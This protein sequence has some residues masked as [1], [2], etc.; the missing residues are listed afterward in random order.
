MNLAISCAQTFRVSDYAGGCNGARV[1]FANGGTQ[2][3]TK[4][5]LALNILAPVY[6]KYNALHADSLTWADLI[7]LAGS[8][9]LQQA[10]ATTCGGAVEVP[11]CPG[12]TDASGPGDGESVLGFAR[13]VTLSKTLTVAQLEFA[14]IL[15]G[16]SKR[17]TVALLGLGSYGSLG[18]HWL[19]E[20][21]DAQVARLLAPL[22][23]T[24]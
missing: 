4:D 1:R 6:K 8:V 13:R 2:A 22:S 11:F 15:M 17:E 18:A 24:G 14:A 9:A 7:V 5:Q 21:S 10:A 12:R 20:S 19:V 16:L 23:H 3:H